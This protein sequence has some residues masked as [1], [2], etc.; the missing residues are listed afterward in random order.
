MEI[1]QATFFGLAYKLRYIKVAKRREKT[2][3]HS[4]S[5]TGLDSL[6]AKNELLKLLLKW[7]KYIQ[8]WDWAKL[9]K[10]I[11][12]KIYGKCSSTNLKIIK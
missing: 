11:N 12:M 4:F 9:Q 7:K 6:W 5:K 10:Y 2:D 8:T 1:I 3:P